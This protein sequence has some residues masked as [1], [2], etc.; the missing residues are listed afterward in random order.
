M[1]FGTLIMPMAGLLTTLAGRSLP[2][3][4]QPDQQQPTVSPSCGPGAGICDDRQPDGFPVTVADL[5]GSN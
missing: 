4:H 5:P 1:L 2:S 3:W